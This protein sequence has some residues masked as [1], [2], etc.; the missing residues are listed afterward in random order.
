MVR[1][2]GNC[3]AKAARLRSDQLYRVSEHLFDT[4]RRTPMLSDDQLARL[5]Q[6]F[7]QLVLDREKAVRA[8]GRY[9]TEEGRTARATHWR[10]VAETTRKTLGANTL[11]T[12]SW[13]AQAAAK[14]QNL[15]WASLDDTEK[16]QCLEASH[17]AGID[18][19]N[20]L[21]ARY[22]GDF[23][24]EPKDK[25]LTR[26]LQEQTIAAAPAQLPPTVQIT[27][28]NQP[29]FS[30][31]YTDF[32]SMMV[33]RGKWKGQMANQAEATYRLFIAVC[34]DRAPSKYTRADAMTFRKTAERMPF[35][36]AK[37]AIYRDLSPLEVI[38]HHDALPRDRQSP[39]LTQ[40]TIKRHFS[41]LSTFW[42]ECFSGGEVDSII[43]ENFQFST[44]KKASD[45]RHQW[46]KEELQALFHSPI[47][48]GCLSA[49]QRGTKG[50]EII[51]DEKFWVPLIGLFSGMR[52][53]EICQL[54]TEDIRE[55]EGV[56]FFDLNDRPPRQLKNINAVRR[57]PIHSQLIR[58]GLL[59]Y[60]A[61]FGKRPHA[62]FPQLKPGGADDKLGHA[63]SK[64]F[65][66]YRQQ[67]SLYRKN[68]DFHSLRH[69]ATT[70]MHQADVSGI[71]ID[72]V[73]G[74]TTPGETAR[75]NKGSKLKQLAA[76]IETI[77]P[78][79]DFGHLCEFAVLSDS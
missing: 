6:D 76:A 13:T 47:W 19:A 14:M 56:A 32:S 75:Y 39:L 63:F 31:L 21:A 62:L 59:E 73:T 58:L 17:R 15:D 16:H 41:A 37:A 12:G 29:L 36:Y 40:K 7:Y 38:A 66:R 49:R 24:F 9:L 65:T 79:L 42:K 27:D 20:A 33:N 2:L 3:D 72:H 53:E 10:E 28:A 26:V 44:V 30:A 57:V 18:L 74:H 60:K 77:R 51:R 68:L 69:T 64:W 52:L 61:S 5:V 4:L 71:I 23:N 8:T 67:I 78:P 11:N 35:D 46:E 25:L 54:Q 34:G 55:E 48:S 50:E 45:E 1:S 43:F 22:D 70:M